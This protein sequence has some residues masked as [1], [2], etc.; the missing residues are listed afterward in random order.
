[1]ILSRAIYPISR[2]FGRTN[3]V[4]LAETML[5]NHIEFCY[6]GSI[7][8]DRRAYMIQQTM[9]RMERVEA[10]LADTKSVWAQRH[11]TQVLKYFQRRLRDM[12]QQ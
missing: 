11:W 9:A 10:L 6:N 8:S 3:T 4:T 2:L 12:D 7:E 5:D 1:M